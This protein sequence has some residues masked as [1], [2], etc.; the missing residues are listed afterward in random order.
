LTT[1]ATIG[2][3][4]SVCLPE[5]LRPGRKKNCSLP[6]KSLNVKYEIE[7]EMRGLGHAARDLETAPVL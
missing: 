6:D 7:P 5:Q 1:S 3:S 2:F 4:L